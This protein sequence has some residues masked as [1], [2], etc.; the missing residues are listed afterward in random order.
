[1]LSP[2]NTLDFVTRFIHDLGEA[3]APVKEQRPVK[4]KPRQVKW[5]HPPAGVVKV[6]LMQQFHV[7]KIMAR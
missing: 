4:P 2:L 6:M 1:L 7:G 3:S 5:I